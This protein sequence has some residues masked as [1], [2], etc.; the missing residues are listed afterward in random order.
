MITIIIPTFNSN[1]KLKR[2]LKTIPFDNKFQVIVIDDFGDESAKVLKPDFPEVDFYLNE[3]NKGAGGARNTGL[4]YATGDYVLFADADD[5]FITEELR[6][7]PLTI[8]EKSDV[9]FFLPDSFL[10]SNEDMQGIR[11]K[12]YK[13]LIE[14]YRYGEQIIRYQF[15][16]PWSKLIKLD[17]LRKHKIIFDEIMYS[18]D[19]MFSLQVGVLAS[20]IEVRERTLY[21]VEDGGGSLT[22]NRSEGSLMMRLT[23]LWRYNDFLQSNG[24]SDMQVTCLPLLFKLFKLSPAKAIKYAIK[25]LLSKQPLLID[26]RY[27]K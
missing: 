14:R 25:I 24:L 23:V 2:L 15:Y 26:Y 4:K 12:K 27:R 11:H 17:L 16:V 22:K 18:N 7:I 19:V 21:L 5:K 6:D 13:W 10:E 20:K 9:I 3:N 8:N 1:D